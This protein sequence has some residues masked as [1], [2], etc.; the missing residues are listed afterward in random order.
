MNHGI[1][2]IGMFK[3]AECVRLPFAGSVCHGNV[4]GICGIQWVPE[5]CRPVV[6][7]LILHQITELGP[8]RNR[9]T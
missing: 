9:Q 2:R 3:L 4:H 5:S 8:Y 6:K 7:Q 1:S